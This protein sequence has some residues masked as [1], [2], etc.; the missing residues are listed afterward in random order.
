M[1]PSTGK[2]VLSLAEPDYQYGRGILRLRIESV[3]RTNPV[4]YE[5]EPWVWVEG[6]QLTAD[7]TEI[8]HR[9]VL[10]RARRLPVAQR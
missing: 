10:V 4:R 6:M 1:S 7:G 5:N 2:P 8:G 9:R 3:D